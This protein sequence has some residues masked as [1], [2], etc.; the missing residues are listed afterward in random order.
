MGLISSQLWILIYLVYVTEG[1]NE[2]SKGIIYCHQTC[3]ILSALSIYNLFCNVIVNQKYIIWK[4]QARTSSYKI[5]GSKEPT[6]GS[7]YIK[8]WSWTENKKAWCCLSWFYIFLRSEEWVY[9]LNVKIGSWCK[10]FFLFR[11]LKAYCKTWT[12]G[13]LRSLNTLNQK[14]PLTPAGSSPYC[15]L[16]EVFLKT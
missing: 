4:N 5:K 6:H 10:T 11:I 12:P 3:R 15:V 13:P 2:Q 8:C 14:G 16:L 9:F 1:S 7:A